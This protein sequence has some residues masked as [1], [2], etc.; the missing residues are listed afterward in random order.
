MM[1]DC[2]SAM[3]IARCEFH[4]VMALTLLVPTRSLVSLSILKAEMSSAC[5]LPLQYTLFKALLP[6]VAIISYN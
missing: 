1:V 4:V 2:Y 6:F 3:F 5:F